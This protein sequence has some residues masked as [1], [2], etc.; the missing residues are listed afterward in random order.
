MTTQYLYGID[1]R[2]LD[3]MLYWEALA[4]KHKKAMDLFRTLYMEMQD[5]TRIFYVNKAINHTKKLL[6]EREE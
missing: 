5:E 6:E 1:V 2:E 3:N 4:Y